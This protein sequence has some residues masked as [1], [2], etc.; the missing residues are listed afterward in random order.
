MLEMLNVEGTIADMLRRPLLLVVM[1]RTELFGFNMRGSGL[2]GFCGVQ[3]GQLAALRAAVLGFGHPGGVS[4]GVGCIRRQV[5]VKLIDVECFDNVT[6]QLADIHVLE[7]DAERT[8]GVFLERTGLSFQI[9]FAWLCVSFRGGGRSGRPLGLACLEA[10]EEEEGKKL[11]TAWMISAAWGDYLQ[12]VVALK[13]SLDL[14][15]TF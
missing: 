2:V 9:R 11:S 13:N 15:K 5:L 12:T 3:R 4:S 8:S 10:E 1:A 6:A 14:L 7:V